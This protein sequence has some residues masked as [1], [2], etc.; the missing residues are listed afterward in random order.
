MCAKLMLCWS[1][2]YQ[3][4]RSRLQA[5]GRW[6]GQEFV[7]G[8][9]MIRWIQSV[10]K[11]W[12]VAAI[13]VVAIIAVVSATVWNG[14]GSKQ[15]QGQGAQQTAGGQRGAA[16]QFPVETQVVKM[17]EVTGGQVFSGSIT[18]VYTTNVSSKV[19]G[20][21]TELMVKAGDRVKVGDPLARMDTTALEQQI[22]QS[23]NAVAI[24][25][26]QLQK[27]VN[28][29]ANS[30]STAEKAVNLQRANLEKAIVDQQNAVAAAKQQVA[31][32][33]ANYNK[34]LNDQQNAIAAAKQ[35]VAISQQ[36]LN[37]AQVTYNTNLTNAQNTLNAQQD[38]VQTS[39][40]NTDN[41]VEALQLALQ[42]AIINYNNVKSS[43]ENK[44]NIDAALQK[45]QTAQLNLDQAQQTTPNA[46]ITA[47]SALLKAQADLITAQ[48][49][50]TVQIA[51]ENL[52]KDSIT[53]ANAQNSLA[54]ILDAN[55]KSLQKDQL[56]YSNA[57]STQELALNVSKAQLAQSE[58]TL[59]SAKSTDAVTVGSA[60]LQQAQTNLQLL[61][62]QL[63]DGVLISPVDGVVT[64]INTPVGQNAG[65]NAN[66]VSIAALNPTQATVNISEANIGKI[67]V[68][69]EMKIT[70]PTLNKTFDGTVYTIRPTMDS[71]TKAY[72][73]DIKVNDPK[74]ELLPGMFATSSLKSEGRKAIMVPADAV[75]SQPSGN[76]VFVVS[77]GKAKKVSVKVGTLTSSQFEI[78]SGLKEGD[79][80]VVKGQEL[81]S[82][83]AAVQIVQPG[84]QQGGGQQGGQ[85][86]QQ[87]QGGAQQQGG[88]QGAQRQQQG[89]GSQQGTQ[90]GQKQGSPSPEG[91][92][93]KQK[94]EKAQGE[95][96]QGDKPKG[97][98]AQ[99]EKPQGESA[100]KGEGSGTA[101]QT[102]RAGGTQ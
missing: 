4:I 94:A 18:P 74:G 62:E 80:I 99:G 22:A 82:D 92:A 59:Q 76:S 14:A 89:G 64:T 41:S 51:Q 45:I 37:N 39:Q 95:K 40:A 44:T 56:S 5:A 55:E 68:G 29:Q 54:V 98:K 15:G 84:Q 2:A 8:Y 24:S 71:V 7:E 87:G 35:Q 30:V 77:E 69:M 83:K 10:S 46:L 102:G 6:D 43:T 88:Q 96:A 90:D 21:V 11:K 52:N 79:E 81:L 100:P 34:A 63:Q 93:E 75:L 70:V 73:V 12:V 16:R 58:Q 86:R 33:Q 48:N 9:E 42:Q 60:Q 31:I 53:L 13:A 67:K 26:A 20:R 47:N 72:G 85:Q 66:I 57:Q 17:A 38:S 101:G 78:V 97:E 28:D 50:Q 91:Q 32:S 19:A 49:S 23:Q 65:T 1:I 61:N 3:S 36:N 27:T 25:S